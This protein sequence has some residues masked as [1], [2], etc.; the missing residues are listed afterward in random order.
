M[1]IECSSCRARYW[2]KE[3]MLKGFKSAEVRC[4]KCGGTF[5]VVAPETVP[6]KPD[7]VE[8]RIPPGIPPG[9]RSP[10]ATDGPAGGR[11]DSPP[12]H[13]VERVK[14][15][16]AATQPRA[17]PV[18]VNGPAPPVPDNVYSL[19]RFREERPKKLPA[20]GYDISGTIR[21]E[22][23]VSPAEEIP[24]ARPLLA[25]PREE[26]KPEQETLLVEPVQRRT[27]GNANPSDGDPFVP[28]R[29]PKIPELSPSDGSQF[30]A[31]FTYSVYPRPTD[32][33]I[34]YLLLLFLGGCG[35]LLVQFLSRMLDGGGG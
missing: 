12:G 15:T 20:G 33:A 21:P 28:P 29:E 22:P 18:E 34:V 35:Y 19:N 25:E 23:A 30:R 3:S 31:G 32:I 4:R 8:R 16:E 27:R 7:P 17:M 5:A 2:M 13:A 24:A 9:S 6:G 10:N 26:K 1:V 14:P 11:G